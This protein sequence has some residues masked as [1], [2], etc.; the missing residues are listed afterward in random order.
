[1]SY[2]TALS[3]V[4]LLLQGKIQDLILKDMCRPATRRHRPS[5][6]SWSI[7]ITRCSRKNGGSK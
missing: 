7:A 3:S 4:S 5:S 2:A 6:R 1:M